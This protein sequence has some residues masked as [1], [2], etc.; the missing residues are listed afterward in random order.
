[1][2]QILFEISN[3]ELQKSIFLFYRNAF[4]HFVNDSFLKK[5]ASHNLHRTKWEHAVPTLIQL[6]YSNNWYNISKKTCNIL[7]FLHKKFIF[8]IIDTFSNSNTD[9]IFFYLVAENKKVITY[10]RNHA[11]KYRDEYFLQNHTL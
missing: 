5:C 10:H 1:M 9:D 7:F 4:F 11:S 2:F 3:I 6:G 8:S